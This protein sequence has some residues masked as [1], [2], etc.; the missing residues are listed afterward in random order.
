[1]SGFEAVFGVVT[2]GAGLISL[3]L[4][5]G[6]CARRLNT[7]YHNLKDAPKCLQRLSFELETMAACLQVM[8]QRRQRQ[9]MNPATEVLT[10]CITAC[11]QATDDIQELLD[12]M[13]RRLEDTFRRG[14][15][16]VVFKEKDMQQL[17]SDLERTKSSIQ[18]AY[19]MYQAEE[20]RQ[21]DEAQCQL[22][23]LQGKILDELPVRITTTDVLRADVKAT[24]DIVHGTKLGRSSKW[25]LWSYVV[26][27][28]KTF[29]IST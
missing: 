17:L 23:T 19:L 7:M 18:L 29:R 16:Y 3:A 20:Q 6:D 15:F 26:L 1:M 25:K 24:A 13:A 2:G 14:R 22:L 5:L 28:S 27:T 11:Q 10:R 8:E 12:K 9:N 21:R 4:Q